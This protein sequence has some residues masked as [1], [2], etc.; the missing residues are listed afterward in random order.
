M[1]IKSWQIA[2]VGTIPNIILL[3][4]VAIAMIMRGNDPAYGSLFGFIA[5]SGLVIVSIPALCLK[6]SKDNT[7]KFGAIISIFLVYLS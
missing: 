6:N 3:L 2:V 7:R 4:L 1:Q 5:L